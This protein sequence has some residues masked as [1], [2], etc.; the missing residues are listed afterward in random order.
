MRLYAAIIILA[1]A[2]LAFVASNAA[3]P[4]E[5]LTLIDDASPGVW[6]T[7][8]AAH[9]TD[10]MCIHVPTPRAMRRQRGEIRA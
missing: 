5:P 6:P 4:V 1:L 2:L 8:A 9:D 7:Y 10:L 3:K